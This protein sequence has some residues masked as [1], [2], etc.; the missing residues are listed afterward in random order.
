MD[1]ILE[2]FS[3]LLDDLALKVVMVDAGDI[4]ALGEI[5][6]SLEA[7]AADRLPHDLSPLLPVVD[8]MKGYIE[9]VIL[10]E[11][12]DLSSVEEAI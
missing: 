3:Q 12:N 2:N 4:P 8:G 11:R 9:K 10:A 1:K 6:T 5:L 7:I